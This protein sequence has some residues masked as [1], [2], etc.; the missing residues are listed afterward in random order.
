MPR[1]YTKKTNRGN[2]P[3][4]IM[5]AAATFIKNRKSLRSASKSFRISRNTLKRYIDKKASV[6]TQNLYG[7]GALKEK[8]RI[9]QKPIEKELADHVKKLSKR[10]YGITATKCRQLT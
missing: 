5:E 2:E 1:I 3:K 7:Y 6:A 10:F 4:E 8:K 9:F